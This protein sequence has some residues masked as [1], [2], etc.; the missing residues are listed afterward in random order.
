MQ[1]FKL[2]SEEANIIK[3]SKEILKDY[4]KSNKELFQKENELFHLLCFFNLDNKLELF[5]N[6]MPNEPGDFL[7]NLK[8]KKIL[9][10]I[11]EYFG[12]QKTYEYINNQL[13]NLYNRKNKKI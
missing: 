7:L 4:G 8:N 10:E 13:N 1:K 6:I 12:N 2:Y 9:I 11:A 3:I 5:K